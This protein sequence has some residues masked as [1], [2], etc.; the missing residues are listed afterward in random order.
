[1]W[2]F[3]FW[4]I[5]STHGAN[6]NVIAI[7][8]MEHP[9]YFPIFWFFMDSWFQKCKIY[10]STFFICIRRPRIVFEILA[11][12]YWHLFKFGWML[13]ENGCRYSKTV[14]TSVINFSS[15]N[16]LYNWNCYTGCHKIEVVDYPVYFLLHHCLKL[17]KINGKCKPFCSIY[18]I[19]P[20]F[21]VDIQL[22]YKVHN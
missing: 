22:K 13:N 4:V 2:T 20:K 6:Y 5:T 19:C 8:Q 18:S 14:F 7:F 16:Q 11:V 12:E 17:E 21:V 3:Y 10:L 1:M 9:V 15:S